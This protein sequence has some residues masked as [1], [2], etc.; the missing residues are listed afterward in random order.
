MNAHKPQRNSPERATELH[1]RRNRQALRDARRGLLWQRTLGQLLDERN[2]AAG[3]EDIEKLK[4][5]PTPAKWARLFARFGFMPV[6]QTGW[7]A[8]ARAEAAKAKAA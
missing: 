2:E 8:R 3:T 1:I 4:S 7:R 5:L 6:P